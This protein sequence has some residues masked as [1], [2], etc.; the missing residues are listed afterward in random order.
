MKTVKNG[1]KIKKKSVSGKSTF[2]VEEDKPFPLF[3]DKE[4]YPGKFIGHELKD[5]LYGPSVVLKFK[6][7][8]GEMTDGE[9]AVGREVQAMMT[10]TLA[11]KQRFYAFV[12][13]L[14][15]APLEQ[16]DVVDLKSFYGQKLMM[17]IENRAKK[18]TDKV[19]SN[20]TAIRK[21]KVKKAR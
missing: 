7:L 15:G 1:G 5:G 17:F 20:V 11:P 2:R 13:V 9:S 4:W 21:R 3:E 19:F 14:N 16:D 12:E 8:G 18:G 10:A 6:G